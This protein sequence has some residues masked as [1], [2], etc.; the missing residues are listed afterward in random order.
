[1]NK[2]NPPKI[3]IVIPSF[4]KGAYI[5]VTLLSIIEQ[6][7]QNLEVIIQDGGSTDGTVE[8]I[9][10]FAKKYPGIFRWESKEDNGQVDAINKGF[11]K[12]E[13]DII[14]YINADDVYKKNALKLVAEMYL[15]HP[16][17]L[18]IAGEGDII[19]DK[20][21]VIQSTVT[22]YKNFLLKINRYEALL[23]INYLIQPAVFLNRGGYLKYGPFTG[24]KKF[25]MEYDLWLKLGRVS[26]PKVIN[27]PLAS[28]RLTLDNISATSFKELLKID[29]EITRKFTNN[30]L[31]LNLHSLHNLGRIALISLFKI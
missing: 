28:F 10:S 24:T 19:D 11:K 13:G 23:C 2:K 21:N 9:K 30:R 27:H 25:V 15:A 7:Y 5:N 16:K 1:M 14:T 3:S 6:K 8:I 17:L 29:N 26:M 4:N 18:W 12:T 22:K 31:I 20:G